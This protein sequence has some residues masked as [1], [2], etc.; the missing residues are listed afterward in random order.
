MT[1]AA[2][3]KLVADSVAAALEAQAATMARAVGLIRWFE[4]TETV[5]SHSKCAEENKVTFATWVPDLM[6]A[7]SGGM[8]Y[9][10]NYWIEQ[11]MEG[12]PRSIEG[13]VTASKPQT[14]EKAIN[15]T[16]RLMDQVTRHNFVQG[17]NDH[18]RKFD[19]RRTSINNQLQKTRNK[20]PMPN[21]TMI[22][23]NNRIEGRKP[24]GPILLPQLKTVVYAENHLCE[25]IVPHPIDVKTLII[26]VFPEDL[27]GL[28]PVR[29]VEFQIDLIPRVAP[30]ARA[31]YRLAP[32]EM[33]ELSN[34]LSKS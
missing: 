13:N 7:V 16:H 5:F 30:V 31:P 3:R 11:E 23:T 33:Q 26:R 15:I 12:L 18:K 8:L 6:N 21:T 34:Q 24:L 14:L 2:I 32:S 19:N 4:W 28:P 1:Q 17:A 10:H 20:Q 22:T 29:Q 27:P 25:E 9:V